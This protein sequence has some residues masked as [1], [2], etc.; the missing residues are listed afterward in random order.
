MTDEAD[1]VLAILTMRSSGETPTEEDWTELEATEGYRRLK[2]RAE[3]YGA[4]A[5]D[6]SFRQW[7]LAAE[8]DDLDRLRDGVDRWRSLDATAAARRAFAYLPAGSR[9]HATIYP[10][11]K[12][13]GN[14][15]VFELANTLAHELHHVGT[16]AACSDAEDDS[17]VGRAGEGRELVERRL[18][19]GGADIYLEEEGEATPLLLIHGGPGGTHL[20]R[21]GSRRSG[22]AARGAGGRTLG[23]LWLLLR[24]R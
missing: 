8:L 2:R 24:W 10:V 4:E 1:A 23:A 3:S 22:G 19:T 15:F 17:P 14:S 6:E 11:L 20:G 21:A 9:L 7:V 13:T 12:K 18:D 5:F 16:V